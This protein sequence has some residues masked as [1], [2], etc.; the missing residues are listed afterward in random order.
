MKGLRI[1]TEDGGRLS[2]I[3]GDVETMSR[4][5]SVDRRDFAVESERSFKGDDQRREW[6]TKA[7]EHEGM[8][9]PECGERAESGGDVRRDLKVGEE[10]V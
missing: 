8:T 4:V 7:G 3:M 2:N 10:N 5:A 9:E 6:S 1:S